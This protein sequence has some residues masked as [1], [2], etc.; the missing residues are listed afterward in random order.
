M[1]SDNL[2]SKITYHCCH[3]GIIHVFCHFKCCRK[4]TFWKSNRVWTIVYDSTIFCV[5]LIYSLVHLVCKIGRG[6]LF[7]DSSRCWPLPNLI[8]N[9]LDQLRHS[10]YQLHKLHSSF[11]KTFYFV[12]FMILWVDQVY[13]DKILHILDLPPLL[14]ILYDYLLRL[15]FR[16]NWL[17]DV[18]SCIFRLS[19]PNWGTSS[20]DFLVTFRLNKKNFEFWRPSMNVVIF[21]RY[22][23]ENINQG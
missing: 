19:W 16:M 17:N 23:M 14:E 11:L 13:I 6:S 15:M 5:W 12:R 9:H 3:W 4:V 2:L 22:G 7:L 20:N 8:S 21:T 10:Q 18:I 1:V